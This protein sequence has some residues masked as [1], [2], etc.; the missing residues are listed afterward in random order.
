MIESVPIAILAG[1]KGT[2]IHGGA[3]SLPKPLVDV[4]GRPILWHVM[5]LYAER[6]FNNFLVLTGWRHGDVE[7]AA[8]TF[9][10]VITGEWHLRTLNTGEDTPTGGRVHAA[11]ELL[12]SGTFGLT[13]ADGVADIDLQAELAFH[14]EH[15]DAATMAVVRPRSPWGKAHIDD[16]GRIDGFTEKPRLESWINGGFMFMEPA[17]LEWIGADD[18][19]ER[20]PL[21]RMAAERQLHAY[22]HEGFWDCMDTFKDAQVL[23]EL[24]AA[25]KPPWLSKPLTEY[26]ADQQIAEVANR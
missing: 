17:A 8:V 19:L 6:G 1:G 25:G 2:R 18:V 16:D 21:E 3:E 24:C 7:A 26:E 13:Y 9:H 14:R 23:N 10:E 4:G 15:Q 20:G 22:K 12:E 5:A 11:R